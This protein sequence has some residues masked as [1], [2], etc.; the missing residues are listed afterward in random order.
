MDHAP[1]SDEEEKIG[2]AVVNAA[3]LVHKTLGPGLL[4]YVYE[5][6]FCHELSKQ[7]LTAHRQV[8]VP[9]IYDGIRFDEALRL[10][11]LVEDLVICELKSVEDMRDVFTAQLL[12]HLRLAG[13]R[14][15]YLINFNVP[16]IKSGIKR[17]IL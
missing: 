10:D 6:C 14:L 17:F 3:Y 4:E 2:E 16:V 5:V 12:T 7:G 8:P 1:L 9:V 13:K 11:V 15:G